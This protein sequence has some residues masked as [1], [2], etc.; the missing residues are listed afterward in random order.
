[1]NTTK[2]CGISVQVTTSKQD[3]LIRFE[4]RMNTLC[5]AYQTLDHGTIRFWTM[6]SRLWLWKEEGCVPSHSASW[7]ERDRPLWL[8]SVGMC[9]RMSVS[10]ISFIV[11]LC[12]LQESSLLKFL[13]S[14]YI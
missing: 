9:V 4:V 5:M 1:M 11:A 6:S 2:R 13:K 3:A 10:S 8:V 7:R 12:D 14:R